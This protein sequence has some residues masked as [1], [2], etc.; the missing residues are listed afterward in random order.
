MVYLNMFLR[1][2][3]ANFGIRSS[4]LNFISSKMGRLIIFKLHFEQDLLDYLCLVNF[5]F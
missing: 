5:D 3:R 4:S 2:S 1:I